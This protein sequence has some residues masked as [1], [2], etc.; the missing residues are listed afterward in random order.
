MSLA[1]Y[2]MVGICALLVLSVG[3]F[4]VIQA[5]RLLIEKDEDSDIQ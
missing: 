2:L 4:F 1:Y 5:L 3:G